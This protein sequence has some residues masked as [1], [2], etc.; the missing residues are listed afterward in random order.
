[1]ALQPRVALAQVFV[2]EVDLLKLQFHGWHPVGWF[3]NSLPEG[4]RATYLVLRARRAMF[5]ENSF[6][7]K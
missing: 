2:A 3:G 1:M 6:V 4:V 7:F 5:V